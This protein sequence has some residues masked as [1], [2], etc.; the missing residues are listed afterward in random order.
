MKGSVGRKGRQGENGQGLMVILKLVGRGYEGVW[1]GKEGRLGWA[2]VGEGWEEW[3][4][5]S[6]CAALSSATKAQG[7]R[8]SR[9]GVRGCARPARARRCQAWAWASPAE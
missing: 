7:S 6:G 3:R 9:P 4:E 1:E 2:V 8:C 5:Q